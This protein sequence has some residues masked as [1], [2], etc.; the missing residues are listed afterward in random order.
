MKNVVLFFSWIGLLWVIFFTP[1]FH[2][3]QTQFFFWVTI[4]LLVAPA[5]DAYLQA[6][7]FFI[8]ITGND[9]LYRVLLYRVMV[10]FLFW[11]LAVWG[12]L[13]ITA[14]Y[15]LLVIFVSWIV[16][17]SSLKT[18]REDSNYELSG[19][20]FLLPLIIIGAFRSYSL[21]ISGNFF[22]EK[23][24]KRK[25]RKEARKQVAKEIAQDLA[26]CLKGLSPF[27]IH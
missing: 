24:M 10:F 14:D 23:K 21:A 7:T 11:A 12:F 16:F 4:I 5:I 15:Y 8:A 20:L 19:C 9:F 25:E 22:K 17:L 18:R 3:L 1:S 13:S 26:I 6:K 27:H 2:F